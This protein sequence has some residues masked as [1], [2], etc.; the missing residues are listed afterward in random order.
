MA[1]SSVIGSSI[2]RAINPFTPNYHTRSSLEEQKDSF[3]SYPS[4]KD[5]EKNR[6]LSPEEL[7]QISELK[8]IEQKVKAHEHAHQSAGGGLAGSIQYQY[9]EGPD[10][11]QYAV[12]GEV[13]IHASKGDTP[14]ETI[15][16]M[17]RVRKAALAP[18]DPSP[19]DL[20]VAAHAAMAIMK[21]QQELA[22]SSGENKG[23]SPGMSF[24]D[25]RYKQAE[26]A[27]SLHQNLHK[28]A[29][30]TNTIF[31]ITA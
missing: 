27:Y 29:V 31:D 2:H 6:E 4:A 22:E 17:E 20:K 3:P 5:S 9:Q 21:A 28:Q 7:R 13:P 1:V 8:T 16:I 25:T 23:K 11:R 19:Q 12:G 14:E 15:E 26:N 24:G 18:A 10:G 30:Q